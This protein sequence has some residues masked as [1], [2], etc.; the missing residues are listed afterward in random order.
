MNQ[1]LEQ[2]AFA[3]QYPFAR[4][5][6]SYLFVGNSFH[7]IASFSYESWENCHVV[8]EDG[9]IVPA[10]QLTEATTDN[11]DE[12][13]DYVPVLAIGSNASP[14]RLIQK[15]GGQK[16]TNIIPVIKGTIRDFAGVYSAH[17][18]KYG[19]IAAAMQYS[20]GALS[21]I[22]VTFLNTKQLTSMH[23]TESLGS[24]YN[25]CRLDGIE[26]DM[27]NAPTITS[28]YLYVSLGGCVYL[29]ESFCRLAEIESSGS[30]FKSYTQSEM[31]E[32]AGTEFGGGLS[33]DDFIGKI[34]TSEE[35]RISRTKE[36]RQ[37]AKPFGYRNT[38]LIRDTPPV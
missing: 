25:F 13:S 27:E 38:V 32:R 8:S 19:S 33:T 4:T 17:F 9:Q 26:I 18:T 3:K 29:D 6:Y 31:L 16:E 11:I 20:P 34:I 22:Y 1:I 30:G 37:F 35:Y 12:L 2:I 21:E 24:H 36:I 15:Y 14:D 5:G 10:N 23:M 7:K 28:A